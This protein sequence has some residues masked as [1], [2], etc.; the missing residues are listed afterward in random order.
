MIWEETLH[1]TMETV[2]GNSFECGGGGGRLEWDR[3]H[4]FMRLT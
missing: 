4:E 1:K 2:E 3:L